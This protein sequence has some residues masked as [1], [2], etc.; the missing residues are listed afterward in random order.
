MMRLH[1]TGFR[2][3]ASWLPLLLKATCRRQLMLD[4]CIAAAELPLPFRLRQ[5]W[6]RRR[7]LPLPGDE[8]FRCH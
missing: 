5:R 2:H 3:A 6:L 4:G 1:D 7:Q 8:P